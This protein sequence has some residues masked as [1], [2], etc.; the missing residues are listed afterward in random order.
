MTLWPVRAAKVSGW[1]NFCA[2]AVMTT[3]TS[4]AWRCNARTNSAALYAAIPPETPTVDSHVSIV[5]QARWTGT[6]A[7]DGGR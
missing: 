3:C 7:V 5:V 1:M 4:T 6:W 2:A